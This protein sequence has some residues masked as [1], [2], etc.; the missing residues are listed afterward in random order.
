MA[1][2]MKSELNLKREGE[3]FVLT[4]VSTYTKEGI[5]HLYDTFKATLD[6]KEEQARRVH[7]QQMQIQEETQITKNR[8]NQIKKFMEAEGI[9]I[10]ED[11][12]EDP[13]QE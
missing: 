2:D 6:L 10:P 9:E 12:V 7:N 1:E 5:L 8:F 11:A 4:D 13:K 3:Q